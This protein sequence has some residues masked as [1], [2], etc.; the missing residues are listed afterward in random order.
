MRQYRGSTV[1]ISGVP[2]TK[3]GRVGEARREKT[4]IVEDMIWENISDL[5]K[6]INP[7]GPEAL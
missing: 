5:M 2:G 3:R 6:T 7:K 4:E 1:Y